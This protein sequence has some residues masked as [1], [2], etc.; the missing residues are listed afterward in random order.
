MSQQ[1]TLVCYFSHLIDGIRRCTI[2]IVARGIILLQAVVGIT[3]T[4]AAESLRRRFHKSVSPE[5]D[6]IILGEPGCSGIAPMRAV[7]DVGQPRPAVETGREPVEQ[8]I[9]KMAALFGIS[10][11]STAGFVRVRA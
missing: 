9:H 4:E 1:F 7:N 11:V 3:A 6:P 8:T 10:S 5:F 2:F